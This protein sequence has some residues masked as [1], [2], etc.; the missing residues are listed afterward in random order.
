MID[1]HYATRHKVEAAE[2]WRGWCNKIPAIKFKADWEVKVIPPFAGAIARFL[3]SHN[4]NTAS[5]Y[6][7]CYAKLGAWDEPYWEVFPFEG[8]VGRCRMAETETLLS[9]IESSL[10]NAGE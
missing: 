5:I 9:M 2:D 8:D 3:V 6:L 1:L 4:G 10:T 7:D